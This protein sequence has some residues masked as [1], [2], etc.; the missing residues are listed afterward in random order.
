MQARALAVGDGKI[1]DV[2][3]AM[4]PGGG[5]AA[6]RP[7]L[8]GV[9]GETKAEPRVEFHRVLHLGGEDV[10]MIEPLRMTAS[11]EV[12][13]SQQMRPPVHRRVELDLEA[14]GIGELQCAALEGLVDEGVGQAVL[15]EKGGCLVEILVVADLEA[16][17]RAGRRCRLAQDERVMLVLLGRAQ[18]NDI[19]VG[20]LD[21]QT[22]HGLVELAAQLQ[23][24]DV[25]HDVAGA[26]DVERRLED[27]LRYGHWRFPSICHSGARS[28]PGI[29]RAAELVDE[30]I[31][32]SL[33]AP[34]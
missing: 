6:V 4:H 8:L 25:E 14:E 28:E 18:V 26:D 5:D 21:M 10:E 34:E 29:H 16:Q 12:V 11:V 9:L 31:P 13:A 33:R 23:V 30:W 2:A 7:V 15:G 32:G 17:P 24:G 22:D 20:I 3:L 19:V 27:V 1:V